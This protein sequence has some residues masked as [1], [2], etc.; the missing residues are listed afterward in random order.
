MSH[1]FIETTGIADPRPFVRLF[2]DAV[3]ARAPAGVK[4]RR[5]PGGG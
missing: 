1:L 3:S 4:A 2:A 5:I